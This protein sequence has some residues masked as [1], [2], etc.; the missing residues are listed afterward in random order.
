MHS[1]GSA[2][3]FI[4]G[5]AA[6]AGAADWPHWRGADRGGVVGEPS[7]WRASEPWPPGEP[8][9][10]ASVGAGAASPLVI[11]TN[12]YVI[13]WSDGR[14][15]VRCLDAGSGEV[16][17]EQ[18][19]AA[20]EYGRQAVGD[21]GFYRGATATPEFDPESGL[22]FTLGCDGTLNAWDTRAD[23]RSVWSL[24]LYDR[25]DV[26][27][28][29]QITDRKGTRRDYG[30]TSA[31]LAWNDWLLVEVGDPERGCLMAFPKRTGG[32]PV[33]TSAN[34]DPAG[35]SGGMAPMEIDG[36]PCVAVAT[37]RHALVVRLDGPNAGRTVAE[38][39][40]ETDFANTIAGVAVHGPDLLISSRYNQMAMA[41]V[42]ISL[43]QGAREVWRNRHPS[44]V[45]TPVIHDGR[46]YFANK[47][48]HCIDFATGKRLWEGGRVGDAGSCL[49]TADER[50]VVWA[51][52]G[53]LALIEGANRSPDECTVL[54]ER[55]GVLADMAWPHVVAANGI[56]IGK[57]LNGDLVCF[58]MIP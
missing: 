25:F 19:Y 13:G 10:R 26:P 43:Q 9:W 21:Q 42:T 45:C 29:P 20:P 2:A 12:V 23:G 39:P 52:D 51:N 57:T 1:G 32:D 14:D 58:R 47:G 5:F 35:H 7:G 11:G 33:W 24:N 30:Y 8:L 56:L 36:V 40:W 15:V 38:F 16:R 37:A 50:L 41:R 17:W 6:A 55:R 27:Q 22:L 44:G 49:V 34:R 54:A 48:V 4:L 28:R 3:L 46:I 53:D 18:G 31:P